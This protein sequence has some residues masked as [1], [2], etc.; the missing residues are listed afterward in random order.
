MNRRHT[1]RGY[2]ARERRT[3]RIMM[4]IFAVILFSGL[5]FQVAM[6]ARLSGQAKDSQSLEMEIRDL[7]A[8]RMNYELSLS[9]Y[10]AKNRLE[11]DAARLGMVRP[12]DGQIRVVN[13]PLAS[14]TS[15]QT[16]E[17]IGGERME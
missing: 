10:K 15:A 5:I 17:A 3:S 7:T 16:A 13:L 8:R 1:K 9:Q 6:M 11:T 2:Y 4:A 12:A 14:N